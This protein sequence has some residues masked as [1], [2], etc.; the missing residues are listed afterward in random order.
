M[1]NVRRIL[2]EF[3]EIMLTKAE[4]PPA[5]VDVPPAWFK[6]KEGV[7]LPKPAPAPNCSPFEQE[8]LTAYTDRMVPAGAWDQ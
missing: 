7:N 2:D 4:V 6:L 3:D 5:M 8:L 1:Q